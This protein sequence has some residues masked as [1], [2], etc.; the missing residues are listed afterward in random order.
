MIRIQESVGWEHI[1]S[2]E[3]M[4]RSKD[5][6]QQIHSKN[7]NTASSILTK[8]LKIIFMPIHQI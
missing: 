1:S 3:H 7:E 6:Q 2:M 8:F 5:T 4:Q